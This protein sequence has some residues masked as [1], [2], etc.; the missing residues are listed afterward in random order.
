MKY[1]SKWIRVNISEMCD[2]VVDCLNRTA[3]H[4]DYSTPYK[5]IRTSN[6]RNGRINLDDVRY[7]DET[8]YKQWTRRAVPERGDIVLTREAPL[9]EV[10]MIETSELVFLGQRTM[11]F[12]TNSNKLNNRFLLYAFQGHDLQEQI[13][14]YGSGATVEHMRVPEAKKLDVLIPPTLAEQRAIADA[15]SEVDDQ[16]TALD[17]LIAK[18]RDIKQ[19]AMQRLLTGEERLPGFSGEWEVKRLGKVAE[20]RKN[21]INPLTTQ[22]EY[23]CVELEH[24]EQGTGRLINFSSTKGQ[25]SIKSVFYPNDV[26]FGKLRPYLRKFWLADRSGVCSTEIW[27]LNADNETLTNEYLFYVIQTDKFIETASLAYGTHMPRADWN[28]VQN[29]ELLLPQPEEQTAI[30]IVLSNMDAEISTLEEKRE[31]TIALKQGMMQELLTGK[32]RL[33]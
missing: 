3:P 2:L 24:I 4:V 22:K 6:V 5:M 20:V 30:T 29:Y 23:F 10:A 15:L 21:R 25:L 33:I 26:L 1:Q 7:V 8:T 19:G 9:G 18:Q 12:R 14:G 31:K 11:M 16:I 27:V 32:T 28:V 13:K 17:D